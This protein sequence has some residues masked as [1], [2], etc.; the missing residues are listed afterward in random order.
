MFVRADL[1]D[2]EQAM[3]CVARVVE[4]YGRIDCLV[5]SAGLT[6]RGTLLD[7]DE[8][9]GDVEQGHATSL[10]ASISR[11]VSVSNVD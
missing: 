10:I 4:A 3:A 9:V 6:S 5:N 2:A 8:V 11:S 7:T 1:A